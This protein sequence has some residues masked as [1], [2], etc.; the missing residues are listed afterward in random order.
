MQST[1]DVDAVGSDR[2]LAAA[3]QVARQGALGADAT[4]GVGIVER[5][6]QRGD[7]RIA[8]AIFDR[9][10]A[11]RGGR[12]PFRWF[13]PAADTAGFAE[14][15]ESGAGEDDRVVVAGVELVQ[16]RADVAAQVEHCQIR[17]QRAQLRLSP[18]R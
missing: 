8:G 12:Q 14:S 5:R 17:T 15:V 1:F 3:L 16:A 9:D 2:N 7:A 10:R 18:Q 4:C 11:L 13:Q 6:K